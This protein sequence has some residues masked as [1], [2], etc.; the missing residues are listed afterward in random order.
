MDEMIMKYIDPRTNTERYFKVE[1][2]FPT[3]Q[4]AVL[5]ETVAP[6]EVDFYRD[7]EGAKPPVYVSFSEA[8]KL[9]DEIDMAFE[10]RLEEKRQIQAAY[11]SDMYDEPTDTPQTDG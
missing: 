10:R 1:V 11:E 7:F 4:I 2:D 5:G 8:E 6:P 3:G 9:Q